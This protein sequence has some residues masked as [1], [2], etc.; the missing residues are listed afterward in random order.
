MFLRTM[1][2]VLTLVGIMACGSARAADMKIG[3]VQI[4]EVF[5]KYKKTTDMKAKL[6]AEFRGKTDRIDKIN[7]L[8]KQKREAVSAATND[9]GSLDWFKKMQEIKALEYQ[10]K[11]EKEDFQRL[12]NKKMCDFY[13]DVFRDFQNACKEFA[14]ASGYSL[15]LRAAD[16][17]LSNESHV[18]IQNEIGLKIL[19]YYA[20]SMDITEQILAHMN[21]KYAASNK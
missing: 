5:A 17:V 6:E 12:L 21:R 7:D 16:E 20:P 8:L 15:I 4:Q 3:V 13:K 14:V 11:L 18:G 2:A 1:T 10:L 9:R 19:H